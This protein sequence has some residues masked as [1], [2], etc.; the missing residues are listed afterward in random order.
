M[1]REERGA[2]VFVYALAMT[3]IATMAALVVDLAQL[4]TDRRVNKTIA[5]TAVRAGLGV[6]QL[7]PWSGVCR[8]REY[9]R[10]NAPGMTLFDAGSEKWFQLGAP[11]NELTSSPCVNTTTSPFINVCVPGQL[12]A[13]RM[14]TW[15]RLSAT[16]GNG[17]YT[18]EIQSGY[19][20]PD[21]RFPEDQVAATDTGDPYKGYCD[22][23][24]VIITEKRLP[25]FGGIVGNGGRRTTIRSVGRLGHVS[26]GE[27]T[28]ALLLLERHK[29]DVLVAGSN[30]TRVI[31]QPYGDHPGV[32]QI[33]SAD[34]DGCSNGQAVLNGANTSGGPSVLA[35]GAMTVLPAPGCNFGI[36]DKPS[37]VGI[38]AL[39]FPHAPGD[40]VT[41]DFNPNL[42][43]STYGDT[44][45]VP[46]AQSGRLP[47]D[48]FYRKNVKVLD[49]TAKTLLRG[50]NSLPPGCVVL[51]NACTDTGGLR[52][53]VLDQ[54]DCD[55]L[56]TN[57]PTHF[58]N[59]VIPVVPS[60]TL[61]QNIWFNCDLSV[62]TVLPLS[63]NALNSSI[64]VTGQL[65]VLGSFSITD[66]RTVY[67]GGRNGSNRIGVD[68]GNGGVLS[69]NRA[70][71]ADCAGRALLGRAT[72]LVVGDGSFTMASGGA[73]FLC[74]TFVYMANGFDKVPTSDNTEPCSSPC[75]SYYGHISIGSGAT[76][77]WSAPNLITNRRPTLADVDLTGVTPPVSP[78]ED[79]AFWTEAGGNNN[80]INGNGN[81]KMTGVFFMGNANSFNLAGNSGAD[82]YL[83]AQF[84]SRTMKVTGGAVVNLVINP[85]DA[86]PVI[87]YQLSL[88][89]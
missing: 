37:R 27:Y 75:A 68:I 48:Y 17:R 23:L 53:L 61:A 8:A 21:S 65:Q 36:G 44:R 31:A 5:D 45:A 58:F 49:S 84:I 52:W 74:Q 34:T 39:N 26:S 82:V 33:D 54:S 43:L 29:C 73:A 50:T 66:P 2:I 11:V 25:F 86:I 59:P 72:K 47:I 40:R 41:T 19:L 63:L 42:N 89:R 64:V 71:A 3:A 60:R 76:V 4:R 32:I 87:V 51:A 7:G 6:L 14:D 69:I 1:K 79:I 13:P 10:A 9:L 78:F 18:I 24:M 88:V 77:D 57:S 16:A 70:S 62:K 22:N 55:T 20:M 30:N 12:G 67:I 80:S 35:C 46:S 83:S 56:S 15:G 38:Y 28:P 81:T 85:V